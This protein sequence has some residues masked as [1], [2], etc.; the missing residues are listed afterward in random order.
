MNVAESFPGSAFWREAFALRGAATGRVLP[1]AIVFAVVAGL[2]GLLHRAFPWLAVRLDVME[3]SGLVLGLLLVF[4]T[5]AGY[6]RWWE[7]RKLWG[8][9]VNQSRNF[10]VNVRAYG[11][12]EDDWQN[13]ARRWTA[14]FGHAVRGTLQDQRELPEIEALL[15]EVE[16]R[17]VSSGEHMPTYVSGRLAGLLRNARD[18]QQLDPFA[19]L[20]ADRERA[21]LLD[22]A[23]AC[24]R[25]L[26][27]P[28]PAVYSITIRRFVVFYLLAL[29]F[30]LAAL[31]DL[32]ASPYTMAIAYPILMLEQ[33]GA[34]LQNPF[35][36][37]SISHIDV[38]RICSMIERDV[39]DAERLSSR[40][41][42]RDQPSRGSSA[43]TT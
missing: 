37:R 30:A 26:K 19:F 35:V 10:V 39:L 28:I 14:A 27:T 23:G 40:T 33:I 13:G 38:A 1:R 17:D 41:Q 2:V 16:A 11:P 20:Q 42:A 25:I 4:R 18:A 6:D 31:T 9:I 43:R 12:P 7:A 21:A 3:A 32:L 22:H 8:A 34:E 5:A 36:T 15:G 29:P 24:E